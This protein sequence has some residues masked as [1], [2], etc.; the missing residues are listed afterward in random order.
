M[1]KLFKEL[2]FSK[3]LAQLLFLL[4]PTVLIV[5]FILWNSTSY[6]SFLREQWKVQTMYFSMGLFAAYTIAQLRFR[7]LPLFALIIIGLTSA[8]A[9]LDNYTV[10]EFD[11]FFISVQ[12]LVFSYLISIG[13]LV[14]WALQRVRY[15]SVILSGILLLLSIFLISKTG[16]MTVEKLL[17]HFTPVAL[18]S[19]YFIY[20]NE[21]LQNTEK[22]SFRFWLVFSARLT[23]FCTVLFLLFGS[24]IYFLYPEIKERVEEFGG[25]GKEGENQMLENK[26]DGSVQNRE[27][28][29]LSGNNK[30][31]T[32]P[33]PLFCAHIE[34]TLPGSDVPN[35]LYLTSY[36]FTLFDTLTET[37]E[38]DSMFK[39]NDEFVPNPSIIPL[40]FTFKDSSRLER[41]FANKNKTVV[42]VEVYKKSLSKEFFVAPSTAF[43]V[44]P[45]TVE[46]DF[47]KEFSSAYRSKSY[48]SE[49]N[50][51]YFIYNSEDPQIRAF[52]QQ[53]F[54]LLRKAKS[55]STIPDDFFRYYTFFP[56]NGQYRPI[57]AL[58]DKLAEG[59]S[60][61]IDKVLAVRDHFL[62]RN[63]IG[64]RIFSYTDNPGVP[65]LPGA[66]KLL[67]FLFDSKKGYCAYYAAA[68]VAL[69]RS[70]NIPC[71]V[72]TGFLTVDR[73]D[74][75][76]GWYWFYDDQSHGW[77]QV[78]FPEYGWIDFDTTVGNE[79][80]EQSPTPDGTPPMEPPKPVFAA[81]G[82]ILSID[83][84]KKIA[85]IQVSNLIF[86]DVEYPGIREDLSLDLRV[87]RIWKDSIQLPLSHLLKGN[88]V[89]AVSYAEKLKSYSPE[90]NIKQL[91]AKL[92]QQ[93]PTDELYI[94]DY[95][96]EKQQT[97]EPEKDETRPLKTY[98]ILTLVLIFLILLCLALL[99]TLVYQWYKFKRKSSTS[100]ASKAYYSYR[101]SSLLLH[102][103]NVQRSTQTH[104][105]FAKQVVDVHFGTDY[106]SFMNLYLKLKYANQVLNSNE[107]QKL[108]SFFKPF[109]QQMKSN[110]SG[111]QRFKSFLNLNTFVKYYSLPDPSSES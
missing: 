10:G 49:L 80:A 96:K 3:Y 43:F 69:L 72:A 34:H 77:V 48:V 37:F 87:A 70:M 25:Q 4:L 2:S 83:T 8:Y 39:Y 27:Q 35:P 86:K 47:Q 95:A 22:T 61:T 33:E 40:F 88:D 9:L 110:F 30:R 23:G 36:H 109:E 67:Y 42:E 85:S 14:G 62:E 20:T 59:K 99:P 58:A 55:Y 66:S 108:E 89:M 93:I 24:V 100:T 78:Y 21:S 65:G 45:I 105:Q 84:I 94:K 81:A 74:K 63:E 91:I 11:H 111:F 60:T 7:F 51:A 76:K 57:K 107:E 68:T 1:M 31:N 16:I 102:M 6:F 101:A 53:R 98:L 13:W 54:D 46:K 38:R 71:R 64:K 82:K 44:Q 56:T 104:W 29:G 106:A 32:N 26:K 5:G 28:M 18:F 103:L 19:I 90:K 79:D 41:E 92:P 52:Q 17:T 12:F 50:S 15:F 75:N 97:T 73:S